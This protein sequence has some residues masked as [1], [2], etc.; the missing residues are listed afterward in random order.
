[1]E[2]FVVN[3]VNL[4]PLK[5]KGEMLGF[6]TQVMICRGTP[7]KSHQTALLIISSRADLIDFVVKLLENRW[8]KS[9][10]AA[11]DEHIAKQKEVLANTCSGHA[12]GF[13]LKTFYAI[14]VSCS[15]FVVVVT[16]LACCLA[17][18]D[19]FSEAS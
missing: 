4:L 18:V 13:L 17:I 6:K 5:S 12:Y 7:V 8:A 15:V 1:M 11:K 14:F 2:A 19:R 10:S 16:L 3:E 9:I